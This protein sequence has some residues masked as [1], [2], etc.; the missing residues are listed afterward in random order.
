MVQ[1]LHQQLKRNHD[2]IDLKCF[3]HL[4]ALAKVDIV[5]LLEPHEASAAS[6]I[7]SRL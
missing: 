7:E 1:K 3:S 6:G 2:H 5:S 4:D